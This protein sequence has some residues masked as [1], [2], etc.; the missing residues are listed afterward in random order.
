MMTPS[1]VIGLVSVAGGL[2][3]GFVIVITGIVMGTKLELRRAE[4]AFELK[5][6]MLERGMTPEEI[7]I[8][9]EAGSKYSK[10]LCKGPVE[11]E[12]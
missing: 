5:R 8:V 4:M 12:V 2:V 11:A 9:M 1:E 7:R 3:C 6:E 10:R